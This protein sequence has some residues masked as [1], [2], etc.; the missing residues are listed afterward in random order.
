MGRETLDLVKAR[1]RKEDGD[2]DDD[3]GNDEEEEEEE[4]GFLCCL[5]WFMLKILRNIV[6]NRKLNKTLILVVITYNIQDDGEEERFANERF[7][8]DCVKL[9]LVF[10]ETN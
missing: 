9:V 8:C 6:I 3:D 5:A 1:T 7:L 4:L 10:I 2:D